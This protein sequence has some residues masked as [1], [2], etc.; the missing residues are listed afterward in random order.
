[1]ICLTKLLTTPTDFL[2]FYASDVRN[3]LEA[4]CEASSR[5]SSETSSVVSS[6]TS[7]EASSQ[8]CC[9]DVCMILFNLVGTEL[10]GMYFKY[11]RMQLRCEVIFMM[12]FNRVG[13][14]LMVAY[15]NPLEFNCAV[16]LFLW[17]CS[18][19]FELNSWWW[20]SN[21]LAL[22]YAVKWCV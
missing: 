17:Y 14:E 15:S 5:T 16:K 4:S 3:S 7:S 2:C 9:E 6:E 11:T 18:T 20:T 22:H 19:G 12:L 21:P 10:M 8:C 1:M 13:T